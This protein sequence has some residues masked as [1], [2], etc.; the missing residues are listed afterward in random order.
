MAAIVKQVL[1]PNADEISNLE[2]LIDNAVWGQIQAD[3]YSVRKCI[4]FYEP[5]AV[6]DYAYDQDFDYSGWTSWNKEQ[7]YAVDRACNYVHVAAAYWS[8]YRVARTYPDFLSRGWEWYLDQAQKTVIR[9]AGDGISY[10]GVGLMGETIFGE[11][12]VDLGREGKTDMAQ[13]VED[14]TREHAKLWDSQEVL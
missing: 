4:F 14:A 11:I 3:D 6:P 1:Q 10:K 13:A 5:S 7:C 2:Q 9:V 8:L 12:L